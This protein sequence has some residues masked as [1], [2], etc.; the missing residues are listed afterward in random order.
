MAE[1]ADGSERAIARA[2]VVLGLHDGYDA[3]LAHADD[4]FVGGQ[5]GVLDA[6]A[7]AGPLAVGLRLLD[8]VEHHADGERGLGVGG[9]LQARAVG[10]ADELGVL[11]G[12]VVEL[13]VVAAVRRV[14]VGEVRGPATERAVGVELHALDTEVVVAEAV[15]DAQVE[16]GVE[17]R[18]GEVGG[19]AQ[20]Q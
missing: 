9:G 20:A 13:P 18:G 5:T 12:R 7:D 4:L 15:H 10:A 14:S 17:E 11:L 6:V 1:V 19:D 8:G 2:K 3:Q 16:R